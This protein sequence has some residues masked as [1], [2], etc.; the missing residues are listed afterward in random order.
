MR[1]AFGMSPSALRNGSGT[2]GKLP[3][4]AIRLRLACREPFDGVAVVR[5]LARHEVPCL[6]RVHG[7]S[8]T[9]ALALEHG[10]G[11]VTLTP[12]RSTLD[13]ELRLED[14]R[15]LTPAVARCRRLFDLDADPVAVHAQL[16]DRP[17]IGELVRAHPGVR[18]PGAVDGFELAVRTILRED[19]SP[20]AA[21]AASVRITRR[22]GQPLRMT[23]E[24][25]S[26]N[27][28]T[29]AALAGA[30]PHTFGTDTRRARA[31]HAL[32][33]RVAGGELALD[34]GSELDDSIDKLLD[35]PGIG[36]W[37]ASYIAMRF[38]GDP[39]AFLHGCR[40]IERALKRIG[41]PVESSAIATVAEGWRPWRA[42][43]VA[44]LW[45]S[46]DDEDE[47]PDGTEAGSSSRGPGQR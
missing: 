10:E 36:P 28:P 47:P 21:R 20:E 41:G 17:V 11:V 37:V 26:H 42:Y 32:A 15:D 31:I 27:F 22:Y 43:A 24:H 16:A 40:R 18:I 29:A 5:F 7:N 19:N 1:D 38:L 13:C 2:A 14:V 30:P 35:V 4:N 9:R 8:Y 45:R 23:S 12:R 6:E 46:L 34:A 25:V 33:T 44:Q 3:A 39:D